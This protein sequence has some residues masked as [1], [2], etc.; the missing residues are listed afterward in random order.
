MRSISRQRAQIGAVEHEQI[1]AV[2]HHIFV[3]R[4]R[5]QRFEIGDSIR[6]GVDRFR[7]WPS[8]SAVLR[9][10]RCADNGQSNRRRSWCRGA[11]GRLRTCICNRM[12]SCLISCAQASSSGGLS[13]FVGRHG[14]MKLVGAS[15]DRTLWTTRTPQHAGNIGPAYVSLQ[16]VEA[17]NYRLLSW[18]GPAECGIASSSW[19]DAALREVPGYHPPG[20]SRLL[21]TFTGVS[22]LVQERPSRAFDGSPTCPSPF[23]P[24]TSQMR[25]LTKSGGKRLR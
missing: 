1:E 24:D 23:L 13:A 16:V 2:R 4:A 10:R 9:L 5:V 18:V 20:A 14:S 6:S 25:A 15:G 11:P 7:G 22:T 3:M 21:R 19:S 17:R 12:P 8:A